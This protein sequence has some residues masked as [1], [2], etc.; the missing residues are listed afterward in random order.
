MPRLIELLGEIIDVRDSK[1][2]KHCLLH[3]LVMSICAMLHGY[4]DFE[5]ICDYAKANE[6]WLNETLGLWNGVPCA[7]GRR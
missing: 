7:N 2:K 3:V 6:E 5:D 4:N 1:G